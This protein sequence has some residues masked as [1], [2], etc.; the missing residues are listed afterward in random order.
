MIRIIKLIIW[1]TIISGW[2]FFWKYASYETTELTSTETLIEVNPG[3][4]FGS[5]LTDAGA[6]SFFTKVYLRDN[7]P[8]FG[9]QVGSYTIPENATVEKYLSALKSPINETDVSLTFLEGWNIFDIDEYLT[10]QNLIEVWEFIEYSENFCNPDLY[11][12]S[13]EWT[14]CDLKSDFSFL[15]DVESLEWYLYPDTYAINPNTFTVK[16]LAIKMLEN[17][18]SKII[19]SGIIT[20]MWSIEIYDIITLASIVEK[21]EK[22]TD[23]KSTVAGILKKRL[24]EWWMIGADITVCYPFRLTAEEC[25]LSVTKYLY[26]VNDY[27][28]RQMV[29]LPA[30]PIWNP[31]A[32]TIEAVVNSKD[33]PYYYYL[34]DTQTGKIYYGATNAEHERNKQLYLR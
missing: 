8:D 18:K 22:N 23:E 24:D 4:T 5:V 3:A 19:D 15:A 32:E 16:T 6:D 29:W 10:N 34:H 25:K 27:N 9:L 14:A 12:W 2:I 7:L 31:S 21:E 20:D 28:T 1:I 13:A 26:E 11:P 17:F 33:T 30:G